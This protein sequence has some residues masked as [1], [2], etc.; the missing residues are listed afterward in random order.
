MCQRYVRELTIQP[1]ATS[2]RAPGV[3]LGSK[4]ASIAHI[5]LDLHIKG[6]GHKLSFRTLPARR[7]FTVHPAVI[8]D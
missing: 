2:E 3:S 7:V 5:V 4:P 6:I 8:A 1:G